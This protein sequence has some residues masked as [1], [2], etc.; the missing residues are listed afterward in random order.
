MKRARQGVHTRRTERAECELSPEVDME[1]VEALKTHDDE[2]MRALWCK[3]TCNVF[4]LPF[5]VFAL[6]SV[7]RSR[8]QLLCSILWPSRASH[9]TDDI[10]RALVINELFELGCIVYSKDDSEPVRREHTEWLK[11]LVKST[12]DVMEMTSLI[13][14]YAVLDSPA[15]YPLNAA[16]SA[17]RRIMPRH[18]TMRLIVQI[19]A[20]AK[21]SPLQALCREGTLSQVSLSSSVVNLP[22]IQKAPAAAT[23]P[24]AESVPTNG[25]A[26]KRARRR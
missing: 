16:A 11:A 4:N 18:E 12:G 5:S 19:A 10:C 21:R 22:N 8:F 3:H 26:V 14:G 25:T 9:C 6:E 17:R 20:L 15:T 23:E 2:C 24:G 7:A 13:K 1:L